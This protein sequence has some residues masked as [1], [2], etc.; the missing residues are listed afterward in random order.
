[1][2][3]Y[4]PSN[5]AEGLDFMADWCDVCNAG[6]NCG[7]LAVAMVEGGHE[8]WVYDDDDEPTCT[9]FEEATA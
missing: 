7:I 9:A 5:G 8:C 3:H 2:I 4:R 6:E 1:M